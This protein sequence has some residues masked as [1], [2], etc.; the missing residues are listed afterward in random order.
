MHTNVW[1]FREL[2]K[3]Q[4]ARACTSDEKWGGYSGRGRPEQISVEDLECHA[5]DSET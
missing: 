2:G 3:P 4:R 1:L 5:T